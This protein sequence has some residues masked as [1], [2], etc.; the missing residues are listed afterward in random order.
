[1]PQ[2]AEKIDTQ[3]HSTNKTET[4]EID[5]QAL[6]DVISQAMIDKKA[7]EVKILD[8]RELTTLTDI[9]VVC[10]ATA[11]VQI[12][13]IA[14]NILNEAREQLNE[15]AWRK[16]GMDARRWVILDYVNV[17]A[18]IFNRQQREF[19]GLERMWND[20]KITEVSDE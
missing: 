16:E 8:V 9:F 18:H 17:V 11:D 7:E 1:M 12:K 6:A 2:N 20:A 15:A 4:G 14:N 5:S 19:Y 10:H 13:A 3:F